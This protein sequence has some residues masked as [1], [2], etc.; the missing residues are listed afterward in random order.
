MSI[1]PLSTTFELVVNLYWGLATLVAWSLFCTL[2]GYLYGYL[3]GRPKYIILRDSDIANEP[4]SI[5]LR[6]GS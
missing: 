3:R 2:S 5:D 6:T 4:P 1:P